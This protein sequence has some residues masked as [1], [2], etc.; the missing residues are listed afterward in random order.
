MSSL[1]GKNRSRY[2]ALRAVGRASAIASQD[3]ARFSSTT[4]RRGRSPR[5][6]R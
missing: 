5:G 4:A 1:S 3:G 6:G 2:P